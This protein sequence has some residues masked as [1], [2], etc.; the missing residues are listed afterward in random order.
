MPSVLVE[1]GFITNPEEINK[2]SKPE[3]QKVIAT[4]LANSIDSILN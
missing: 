3:T 4:Q 2:I 1:T